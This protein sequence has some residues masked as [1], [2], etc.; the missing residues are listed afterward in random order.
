MLLHQFFRT[1]HIIINNNLR[2]RGTLLRNI[3]RDLDSRKNL[4]HR[5]FGVAI[6]GTRRRQSFQIVVIIRAVT[7]PTD[8]RGQDLRVAVCCEGISVSRMSRGPAAVAVA[9]GGEDVRQELG[10]EGARARERGADNCDVALDRGPGCCADIVVWGR[11][12]DLARG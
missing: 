3:S 5:L 8:D 1:A 6:E 11:L 2:M 9:S 4:L 7:T 10:E 12:L